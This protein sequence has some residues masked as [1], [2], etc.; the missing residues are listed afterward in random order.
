M[1]A[2]VLLLGRAVVD[3]DV[4]NYANPMLM[5]SV[6]ERPQ[7]RAFPIPRGIQVIQLARQIS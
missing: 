6:D 4:R 7:V 2:R 1:A 5:E 3:H